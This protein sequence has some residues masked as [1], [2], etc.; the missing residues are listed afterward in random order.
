MFNV[1]KSGQ[2]SRENWGLPRKTRAKDSSLEAM[3]VWRAAGGG[4]GEGGVA[5][6]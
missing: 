2:T 4:G 6:N 5:E 3:W 1:Y